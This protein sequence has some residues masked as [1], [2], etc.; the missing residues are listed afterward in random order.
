MDFKSGV[1][2]RKMK[3]CAATGKADWSVP[4]VAGKW[5][6]DSNG[7][8]QF[9]FD[10]NRQTTYKAKANEANFAFAFVIPIAKPLPDPYPEDTPP[11]KKKK[12]K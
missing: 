10:P 3:E 6:N 8:S 4:A 2:L 11:K 7:A 9:Q 5:V 1:Y 12:K